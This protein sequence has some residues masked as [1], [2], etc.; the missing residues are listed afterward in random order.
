MRKVYSIIF[1][2]LLSYT[3]IYSFP[4]NCKILPY[5]SFAVHSTNFDARKA[6]VQFF[7]LDYTSLVITLV[8]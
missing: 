3:P 7:F 6:I 8:Y 1:T 4:V 2:S 5:L